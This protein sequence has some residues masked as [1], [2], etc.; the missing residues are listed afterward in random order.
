MHGLRG[1]SVQPLRHL[2]RTNEETLNLEVPME[3]TFSVTFVRLRGAHCRMLPA[4]SV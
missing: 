4:K 3:D 2:S 1:Y